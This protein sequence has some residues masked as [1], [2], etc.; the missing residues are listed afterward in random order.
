MIGKHILVNILHL[1]I[2]VHESYENLVKQ[3]D[4]FYFG[5]LIGNN[6]LPACFDQIFL[7]KWNFWCYFVLNKCHESGIT[8]PGFQPQQTI[9]PYISPEARMLWTEF[10]EEIAA[11]YS[12]D[13]GL[14]WACAAWLERPRHR[15]AKQI[16]S[17]SSIICTRNS[18]QGTSCLHSNYVCH[19]S[20]KQSPFSK[21]I[22]S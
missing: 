19:R 21:A 7:A 17:F 14:L 13:V 15:L 16:S 18:V 4:F 3:Q 12:G 8:P 9:L 20:D 11:S 1:A 6:N 2:S 5:V 22:W 10:T